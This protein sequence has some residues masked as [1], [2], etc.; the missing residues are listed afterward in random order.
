MTVNFWRGVNLNA[1][2]E[3]ITILKGG[4]HNARVIAARSKS[5]RK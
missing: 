4:V 3:F 5:A 1:D 2:D